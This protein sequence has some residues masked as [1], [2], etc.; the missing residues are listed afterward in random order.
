LQKPEAIIFFT[1]KWTTLLECTPIISAA[2]EYVGM[3][4]LARKKAENFFS[5]SGK[6]RLTFMKGMV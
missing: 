3:R 5:T 6:V 1:Q 4:R 2:S